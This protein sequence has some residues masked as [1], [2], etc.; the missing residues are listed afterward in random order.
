MGYKYNKKT[1]YKLMKVLNISSVIRT[2]KRYKHGKISH[3]CSNKLNREFTSIRPNLKW[4]T[5]VTEIK[6]D[7]EKV[8]LSAIMDLYNREIISY[9]LSKY[10]N[11]DMVIDSLQQAINKTNDLSGLMIHS[12]QGILYQAHRYRKLLNENKIEQ[13]MSKR[14]NCYD[15][16]VMESFFATLKC[17]FIYIN[18]FKNIE[19]FKYKLEKYIY[20]YN[21]HRIKANGLTP[22]QEKENYLVA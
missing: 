7:K 12:D 11:E 13:S 17:E 8:Y 20:F 10:N 3:I 22:M 2:K 14:G 1:V 16:A 9:S 15:N 19:Q 5:D 4:V 18:Q 6:I 21:N